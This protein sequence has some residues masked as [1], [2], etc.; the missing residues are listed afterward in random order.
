M[1]LEEGL[2]GQNR[3]LSAEGVRIN[4]K[5]QGYQQDIDALQ[6]QALARQQDFEARRGALEQMISQQE[7]QNQ[8][9][10][11]DVTVFHE[12][13]SEEMVEQA[14]EIDRL[15]SERDQKVQAIDQ[16]NK[17]LATVEK[18]TIE[19]DVIVQKQDGSIAQL[20]NELAD[21]DQT[22]RKD[23]LEH[24]QKI[25]QL[26]KSRQ[27]LEREKFKMQDQYR[28]DVKSLEKSIQQKDAELTL[29]EYKLAYTEFDA[30]SKEARLIEKDQKIRNL[31]KEYTDLRSQAEALT[32][33]IDQL[34]RE[35]RFR[36]SLDA[37]P[38]PKDV[39]VS[40]IKKQ[41]GQI[42]ELKDRLIE[43][44]KRLT[45]LNSQDQASSEDISTL[46]K[47]VADL[48]EELR[49]KEQELVVL[50]DNNAVLEARLQDAQEN[51]K[52]VQELL[53]EREEQIQE[54]DF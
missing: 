43:A 54:A 18:Q 29:K 8:E 1:G 14:K 34:K 16:L 22:Y 38:H 48:E 7:Q 13:A 49:V 3:S 9:L 36:R 5:I 30:A 19:Q 47:Q 37:S 41:D 27:D 32:Q 17:Q 45:E 15:E 12:A 25:A 23:V 51:L 4:Q 26:E 53:K 42:F 35:Q 10:L 31:Q 28:D 6:Q 24:S 40:R 46:N 52:I 11:N 50:Q 44:R 2:Y 21:M 39:L 20:K 33:S